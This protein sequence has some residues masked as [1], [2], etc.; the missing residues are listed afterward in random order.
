MRRFSFLLLLLICYTAC[1][2][3]DDMIVLSTCP[4]GEIYAIDYSLGFFLDRY[5]WLT[6]SDGDVAFDEEIDGLLPG[7]Q[8]LNFEEACED[9]YTFSIGNYQPRLGQ[10]PQDFEQFLSVTEYNLV[11]N[12]S[13]L[14]LQNADATASPFVGFLPNTT[15]SIADCPPIDSIVFHV[16]VNPIIFGPPDPLYSFEYSEQDSVLVLSSEAVSITSTDALLAV[17]EAASGDWRGY[18]LNFR[19]ILPESLS[20][21]D[22]EPVRVQSIALQWPAGAQETEVELRWLNNA[23]ARRSM[24]LAQGEVGTSLVAPVLE[25]TTG[26]FILTAT[27]KGDH[28]R[29]VR[30]LLD[31]WPTEFSVTSSVEAELLS[32]DYP[33]LEVTTSGA[34]V[35]VAEGRFIN[36]SVDHTVQR[37][38]YGEAKGGTQEIQFAPLSPTINALN[39]QVNPL[40]ERGFNDSS[41]LSLFHY[42]AMQGSYSWYFRNIL[43][44]LGDTDAW[45]SSLAYERLD[46]PFRE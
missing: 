26:P 24:I 39:T 33:K 16:Y 36:F 44:E 9:Q 20:Y 41:T 43:S 4:E 11:P 17:R 38:Y 14:D 23:P 19:S 32:F 28:K 29:E 37:T 25:S 21:T 5:I 8:F 34:D 12:G 31:S 3:D 22:F 7:L 18:N 46:L 45:L 42:P 10:D 30:Y 35:L 27:W 15:I 1:Q 40:Y 6:E 13:V 2:N